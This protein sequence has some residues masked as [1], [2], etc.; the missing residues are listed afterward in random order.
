MLIRKY[1]CPPK[2]SIKVFAVLE[3]RKIKE[4]PDI[5][6]SSKYVSANTYPNY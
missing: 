5:S 1:S 3:N 4:E 2:F 6:D